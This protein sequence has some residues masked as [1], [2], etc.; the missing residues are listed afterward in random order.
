[1]IG[2]TQDVEKWPI[3]IPVTVKQKALNIFNIEYSLDIWADKFQELLKERCRDLRYLKNVVVLELK[4]RL[5]LRNINLI[6][7]PNW[8]QAEELLM[9]ELDMAIATFLTHPGNS[10]MN[11]LID[12][13][14]ISEEETNLTGSG[15]VMNLMMQEDLEVSEESEISVLSQMNKIEWTALLPCLYG[16]IIL[17]H[18]SLQAVTMA[19]AD[20][21]SKY[22]IESLSRFI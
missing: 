6:M 15:I 18:K 1:M 5:K 13:S 3:I 2:L 7:F 20:T 22:N 16:R 9:P 12:T 21:V 4:A 14:D 19:K 11:L 17:A 8:S 10:Q